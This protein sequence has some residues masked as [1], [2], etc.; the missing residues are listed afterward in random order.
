MSKHH[1]GERG[2]LT[3]IL[4]IIVREAIHILLTVLMIH[5]LGRRFMDLIVA[6]IIVVAY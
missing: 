1:L 3:I 6:D 2:L 4:G 5:L